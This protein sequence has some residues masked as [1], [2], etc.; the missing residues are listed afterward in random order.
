M[1]VLIT[2]V[3]GLLGCHL[4]EHLIDRGYKVVGID[5]LSGGYI[6]N[7]PKQTTFYNLNLQNSE[8]VDLIFQNLRFPDVSSQ[9]P[10]KKSKKK[11]VKKSHIIWSA[12]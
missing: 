10:P 7:V 2:G 11:L 6:E 12:H 4:A 5:D 8:A 3:G 1:K 9:V